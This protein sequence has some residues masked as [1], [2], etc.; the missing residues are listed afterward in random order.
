MRE[1]PAGRNRNRQSDRKTDRLS[2]LFPAQ[3]PVQ[4]KGRG[5]GIYP[6]TGAE[7]KRRQFQASQHC[8]VVR[9]SGQRLRRANEQSAKWRGEGAHSPT[10]FRGT[11]SWWTKGLAV[12]DC[13]AAPLQV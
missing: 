7:A 11:S 6:R 13:I 4:S 10:E 2:R 12:Y 1:R 3:A 9:T 5:I 8:R